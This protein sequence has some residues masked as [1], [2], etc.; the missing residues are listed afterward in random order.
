MKHKNIRPFYSQQ[1]EIAVRTAIRELNNLPTT[2]KK[3]ERLKFLTRFKGK[4]FVDLI[5]MYPDE[6]K[7]HAVLMRL[8]DEE[9]CEKIGYE[10]HSRSI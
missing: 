7:D 2:T 3:I 1:G 4:K 5:F 9:T 6:L 10:N 8:F